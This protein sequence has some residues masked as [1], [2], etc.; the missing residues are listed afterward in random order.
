MNRV[1]GLIQWTM[2]HTTTKK[3]SN[4]GTIFYWLAFFLLAFFRTK[5]LARNHF[6][7]H[8]KCLESEKAKRHRALHYYYCIFVVVVVLFDII[9]VFLL[10]L[11][12]HKMWFRKNS[13]N[14]NVCACARFTVYINIITRDVD[15][16]VCV[17]ILWHPWCLYWLPSVLL[18]SSSSLSLLFSFVIVSHVMRT[19]SFGIIFSR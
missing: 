4:D 16:V 7:C 3:Q 8:F 19:R 5:I 14:L 17:W 12:S 13:S 6:G 9:F 2:R 15:C 10:F 11:S 1:N 18:L